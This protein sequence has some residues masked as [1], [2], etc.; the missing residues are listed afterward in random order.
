MLAINFL[1]SIYSIYLLY[2]GA[3]VL[4]EVPP[5]KRGKFTAI[6]AAVLMLLTWL[7]IVLVVFMANAM[8]N[9]D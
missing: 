1:A 9:L 3:P 8:G 5:E 2:L 4:L 6:S 7:P